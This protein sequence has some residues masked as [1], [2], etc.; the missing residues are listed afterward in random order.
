MAADPLSIA[1]AAVSFVGFGGQTLNGVR[2]LCDFF[3]NVRDA[4]EDIETIA[5]ELQLIK[6]I[7]EECLTDAQGSGISDP[8]LKS[9]V[10]S[11]RYWTGKL[12]KRVE[13]FGPRHAAGGVRRTWAQ[14]QVAFR[15]K[16][17]DKYVKGLQSAKSTLLHARFHFIR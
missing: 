4:P 8:A 3:A 10:Q 9:A 13:V 7:L 5:Q 15:N 2:F 6:K 1:S 17:I 11:C 12:E 14:V 16:N